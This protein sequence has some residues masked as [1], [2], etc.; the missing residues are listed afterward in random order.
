MSDKDN[1]E[2]EKNDSVSKG[3]EL[4]ETLLKE[5]T[6]EIEREK[7]EEEQFHH[8]TPVQSPERRQGQ[9]SLVGAETKNVLR[10]DK[11]NENRAFG[12][13]AAILISLLVIL[14]GII[15]YHLGMLEVRHLLDYFKARQ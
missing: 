15:L 12:P 1:R 7:A 3:E 2:K 9:R 4:F 5:A 6:L 10:S 13:R 11:G 14:A 8:V